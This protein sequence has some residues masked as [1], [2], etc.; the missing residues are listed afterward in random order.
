MT[1]EDYLK[2]KASGNIKPNELYLVDNS[3]IQEFKAAI[4]ITYPA[5]S[6]CV[7]KNEKNETV[8]SDSNTGTSSKTWTCIV[9]STG[10]YRIVATAENG[11]SEDSKEV[12][13]TA[14]GQTERLSLEFPPS[15]PSELV[16]F[17]NG[18]DNTEITGGWSKTGSTFS[19][20]KTVP[21]EGADSVYTKNKV[22][23]T[24]YNTLHFQM[25]EYSSNGSSR[26]EVGLSAE[27][28]AYPF[29]KSEEIL[30]SGEITVDVSS[31]IGSFY[32]QMYLEVLATL[33]G[34]YKGVKITA[35]KVWLTT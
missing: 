3:S 1:Q 31:F 4:N 21:T 35:S 32:I 25:I 19:L 17:D 34:I 29:T 30:S 26:K 33:E 12:S 5:M 13:I 11:N 7:V 22:D 23:V 18:V 14:N 15:V 27:K 8:S 16:L 28:G 10:T 20:A 2:D 24:Y 6:N 9:S